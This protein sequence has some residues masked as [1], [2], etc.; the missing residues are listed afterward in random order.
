MTL[1]TLLFQLQ[2]AIASPLPVVDTVDL[3]QYQ[4]TW[5]EI[6][7]L[8]NFFQRGCQATTATYTPMKDNLIEVVNECH[9]ESPEGPLR[10]ITGRAWAKDESN[11]KLK[12]QFFWPFS[13]NYWITD[14]A[15]DYS[16]AVVGDPSRKYLW[17]LS[18]S[19]QMDEQ[20]YQ[21]L[22]EGAAA[23]EFD[24]SSLIRTEHRLP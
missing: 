18:R 5:Y 20:L 1:L 14:L 16:W 4:G 11:A 10:S 9:D 3:N 13:G 7:R 2:A 22:L 6:A 8:P 21:E 12:V 23:K 15:R 24:V 19:P 17:I